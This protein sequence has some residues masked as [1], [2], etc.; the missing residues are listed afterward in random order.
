VN[1][2]AA[3]GALM[4]PLEL[5]AIC[6]G[7]YAAG[8]ILVAR[9]CT[10]EHDQPDHHCADHYS[11]GGG[12]EPGMDRAMNGVFWPVF[13]IM[14]VVMGVFALVIRPENREVR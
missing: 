13:A 14:M 5:W 6:M 2:L 8:I 1:W 3:V 10:T 11:S 12:C 9:F 4:T 7:V